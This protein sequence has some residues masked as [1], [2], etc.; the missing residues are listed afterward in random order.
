MGFLDALDR[1]QTTIPTQEEVC[2]MRIQAQ[3]EPLPVNPEDYKWEWQKEYDALRSGSYA[4]MGGYISPYEGSG[5]GGNPLI[6]NNL[7]RLFENAVNAKLEP[8]KLFTSE[9]MQLRTI[10]SDQSKILRLFES[11]L[12]ESL[13]DR[14]KTGLSELDVEAMQ[15]LTAGKNI[16]ISSVKEQVAIKAKM[17]EL[18][19][20]QQSAENSAIRT[21]T[22]G[23]S[24]NDTSTSIGFGREF[25]DNIFKTTIPTDEI[26]NFPATIEASPEQAGSIL[27]DL[28]GNETKSAEYE[29][30]KIETVVVVGEEESDDQ[31]RF[32]AR[33][34]T[35]KIIT[36]YPLP[37]SEI[38][39]IDRVSKVATD[40][41]KRS[42]K[43]EIR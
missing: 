31:A 41:L 17:A 32:I 14:G 4:N 19:I 20:K 26:T 23:T 8:T 24:V 42:W 5:W 28:V 11:K 36:D 37:T 1:F 12:K 21:T 39:T 13:T 38:E 16:L 40:S 27:N 25:M 6:L 15:A 30:S 10:G 43:V 34:S 22:S 29:A 9:T 2:E 18:K 3:P 7:E 35:G 33:D